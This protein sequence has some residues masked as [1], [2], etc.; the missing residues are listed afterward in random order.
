MALEITPLGLTSDTKLLIV[1]SLDSNPHR[2]INDG[3][4]TLYYLTCD[5]GGNLTDLH[6]KFYDADSATVGT[7]APDMIIFVDTSI[8]EVNLVFIEGIAFDTNITIAAVEEAGTA[9]T[10]DPTVGPLCTATLVIA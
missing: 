6:F 3:A 9:G 4:G 7:T 2:G 10:T 5:A 1:T 8:G